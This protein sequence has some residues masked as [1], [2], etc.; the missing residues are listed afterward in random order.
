MAA[1][2][3]FMVATET[4]IRKACV[5]DLER[6][7]AIESMSQVMPW[8]FGDFIHELNRLDAEFWVLCDE[9]GVVQGYG[10]FRVILDE[11]YVINLTVEEG[12]RR[13]GV[14]SLLMQYIINRAH[15]YGC[16]RIVLD[17][18]KDNYPAIAFY[19]KWG[20]TTAG[21]SDNAKH[22]VMIKNI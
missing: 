12:Q 6:I 1:F 4:F 18:R 7:L 9:Y 2:L 14:G 20:F 17:V 19:K 15:E 10:I 22:C 11:C 13:K 3:F 8:S 5:S 21:C 16:N